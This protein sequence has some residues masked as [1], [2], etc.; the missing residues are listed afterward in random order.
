L[1]KNVNYQH[2]FFFVRFSPAKC[3][4]VS[5]KIADNAAAAWRQRRLSLH[6]KR[7]TNVH[8]RTTFI[9]GFLPPLRQTAR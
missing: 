1:S 3:A 5:A 6:F 2:L 7:G 8:F 9:A 4:S